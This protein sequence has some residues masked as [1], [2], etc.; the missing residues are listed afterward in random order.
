MM[1]QGLCYISWEDFKPVREAL[2]KSNQHGRHAY[3]KIRAHRVEVNPVYKSEYEGI[4]ASGDIVDPEIV[5]PES[6]AAWMR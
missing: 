2:G 5:G 4:V 6:V 1:A 3:D